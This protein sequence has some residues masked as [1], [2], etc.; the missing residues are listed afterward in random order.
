M[1]CVIPPQLL[2]LCMQKSASLQDHHTLLFPSN[3]HVLAMQKCADSG[4]C[5]RLRGKQGD[6]YSVDAKS[7][8]INGAVVTAKVQHDAS[9]TAYDLQLT[10]YNGILRMHID[11]AASKHRFQVPW[12]LQSELPDSSQVSRRLP[13]LCCMP[14]IETRWAT[15]SMHQQGP[16]KAGYCLSYHT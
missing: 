13:W 15:R 12:V 16:S 5:E 9:G 10:N 3:D 11:E 1:Y 2:M 4:F 7:V 6:V 14:H 8:G